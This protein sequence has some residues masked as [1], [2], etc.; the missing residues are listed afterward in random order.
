MTNNLLNNNNKASPCEISSY[1]SSW[2]SPFAAGQ[3]EFYLEY[4]WVQLVPH[5]QYI[6][7]LWEVPGR[8]PVSP[9]SPSAPREIVSNSFRQN[10]F[11]HILYRIF[12]DTFCSG[13]KCSVSLV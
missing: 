4:F 11:S 10:T 5:V 9:P 6:K 8:P 7:D 13:M 3:H 12:I 1:S 2:C